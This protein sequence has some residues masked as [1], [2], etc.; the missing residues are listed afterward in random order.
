MVALFLIIVLTIAIATASAYVFYGVGF[1]SYY[2]LSLILPYTQEQ[3]SVVGAL[4][5]IGLA[6]VIS[7]IAMVLTHLDREKEATREIAVDM[8]DENAEEI[9]RLINKIERMTKK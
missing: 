1:I 7:V 3:M 5:G 2:G 4:I 8:N 6:L 9:M